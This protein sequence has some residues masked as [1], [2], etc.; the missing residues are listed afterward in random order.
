[1]GKC[2]FNLNLKSIFVYFFFF[3]PQLVFASNQEVF[4]TIDKLHK[5]ITEISKKKIDENN[6]NNISKIISDTYDIEKMSKIILGNH[7]AQSKSKEKENFVKK[8]TLYISSSYINKFQDK[9]E[10]SYE[11]KGAD[12]IGENYRI[13]YTI[14]K[15]DQTEKLKIN[16]ML[17][18]KQNKWLIFDVLFNGSISEIATKKSEFHETLSNGGI[19]SVINIISEKLKF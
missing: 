4:P 14:F 17:I 12:S 1:M 8:F 13:A 6:I 10:F 15:F 11:Y 3:F 9:K 5:M 18:K 7:W 19:N 16:Y 2:L